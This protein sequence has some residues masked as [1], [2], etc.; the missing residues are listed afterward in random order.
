MR[1]IYAIKLTVRHFF[2]LLL[3]KCWPAGVFSPFKPE[4]QKSDVA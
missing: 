4:K 1:K 3:A 2:T